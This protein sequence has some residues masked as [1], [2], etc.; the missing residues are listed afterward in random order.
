MLNYYP[1]TGIKVADG[2][3]IPVRRE[4]ASWAASTHPTDQIQ[5]SLFIRALQIMR[6][7]NL[8]TDQ[9]SFYRVAGIHGLP[10]VP[11]DNVGEGNYCPHNDFP[12]PTWHRPYMLLYEQCLYNIM[13]EDIVGKI[14]DNNPA[15][16]TWE[17]A[18]HKWRLPYWDWAIAQVDYGP[19][20]EKLGVPKIVDD[21][22]VSILKIGSQEKE[23]VP[24][25]LYKYT[26]KING[27]RVAMG[28]TAKMKQYAL[29][30]P[31]PKDLSDRDQTYFNNCIGTSRYASPT[32]S[33]DWVP[34]V[35]NNDKVTDSLTKHPWG[36]G[37]GSN[38]IAHNVFRILSENYFQSYGPFATTRYKREKGPTKALEFFSLEQIHNN[39]HLWTGGGADT[40]D[41]HMANVPVAAFDPIFWLHHCN[42]DR[43]FALWQFVNPGKWFD[44]TWGDHKDPTLKDLYPFHTHTGDIYSSDGTR[45]WTKLGYTYPELVD[46]DIDQV[47]KAIRNLYDVGVSELK[48]WKTPSNAL[49][50]GISNQHFNDYIINVEYDRYALG[51]NP[52]I[53]NFYV[54]GSGGPSTAAPIRHLGSFYTFSSPTLIDCE[55]CLVQK[56]RGVKS[57]AQVPITLPLCKLAFDE[58][59]PDATNML[60]GHVGV[61]LQ[62]QL[63]WTVTTAVGREIPLSDVRGLSVSVYYAP[64]QYPT[65]HSLDVFPEEYGLLLQSDDGNKLQTGPALRDELRA[66]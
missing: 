58:E 24:N 1:I 31:K 59:Y 28:D 14:P 66:A 23:Q 4:I 25:P 29:G 52:Y 19:G 30:Y 6:D 51:G 34:G 41:G 37:G 32:V 3:K 11:W 44:N 5:V 47:K 20:K 8:L 53:V 60:P 40:T 18:M 16:K 9:L 64:A 17:A 50:G 45:D 56:E 15:K 65:D 61:Q 27:E 22:Q 10:I 46:T 39:I 35:E 49:L 2:E 43:L 26:N 7:K 48:E 21:S 54:K 36:A 38:T 62:D 13:E 12:F 57:K 42:V 33:A 63:Y 55:N